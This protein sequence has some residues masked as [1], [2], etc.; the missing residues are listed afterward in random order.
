MVGPPITRRDS[1]KCLVDTMVIVRCTMRRGEDLITKCSRNGLNVVLETFVTLGT[2][3]HSIDNNH[4]F[5]EIA[6]AHMLT[7]WQLDYLTFEKSDC[8]AKLLVLELKLAHRLRRKIGE[9]LLVLSISSEHI[10]GS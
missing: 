9:H 8:W 6:Q 2:M 5:C 7:T 10:G 1:A 4:V 3:Q